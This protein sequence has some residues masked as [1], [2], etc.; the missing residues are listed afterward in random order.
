MD[1]DTTKQT[2]HTHLWI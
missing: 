2:T 1:S